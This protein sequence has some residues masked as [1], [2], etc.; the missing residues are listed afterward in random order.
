MNQFKYE[1]LEEDDLKWI[2]RSEVYTSMKGGDFKD[3]QVPLFK[4][5]T[6]TTMDEFKLL[7]E[8][9][10]F[11]KVYKP[12]PIELYEYLFIKGYK[13]KKLNYLGALPKTP[14]NLFLMEALINKKMLYPVQ[15]N[16]INLVKI[17]FNTYSKLK[18]QLLLSGYIF[19]EGIKNN[20]LEICIYLYEIGCPWNEYTCNYAASSET[21]YI[22]KWLRA[23]NPPCPWNVRTPGYAARVGRI[24]N[25]RWMRENGCLWDEYTSVSASRHNQ[26]KTVAWLYANGCPCSDYI[27]K[28][29]KVKK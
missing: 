18:T 10:E 12:Y 15:Q 8:T 5:K 25:L 13:Q 28:K 19:N 9:I 16:D 23:Q 27:I 26:I 20:N 24:D 2:K 14:L 7:L 6:L 22:L 3:V 1:E 21:I 29:N 11:W 17:T 4:L